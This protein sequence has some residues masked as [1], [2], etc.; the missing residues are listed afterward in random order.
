YTI[1]VG[2]SGY[3][4]QPV[5]PGDHYRWHIA[6]G[7]ELELDGARHREEEVVVAAEQQRVHLFRQSQIEKLMCRVDDMCTPVAQCSHPE[8]V[9]AAPLP[10]VE[11]LVVVV[12]VARHQPE[13]P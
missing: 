13:V 10:V 11:V 3:I 7:G 9:P 2:H 1:A 5:M 4:V 6:A 12:M 8:I